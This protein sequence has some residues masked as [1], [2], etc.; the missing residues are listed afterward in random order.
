MTAVVDERRRFGTVVPKRHAR[1]AVTRSLVKREGRAVFERHAAQMKT[2]DWLL[3][4]RS[5]FALNRF[6]SAASEPLR[7]AVRGELDALFA[8]T[9]VRR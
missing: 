9:A 5:P 7:V 1:R 4:L 2:G 8:A 3:R 6:P